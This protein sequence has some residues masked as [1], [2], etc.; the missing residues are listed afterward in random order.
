VSSTL[1]I[2]LLTEELPPKSLL[3]LSRSFANEIFTALKSEGFL[4]AGSESAAFATPRRLA[5]RITRVEAAQPDRALERKGPQVAA[6]L[7]AS[8]NPTPALLGFASSCGVAVHALTK[9]RSDKGEYFVYRSTKPGEKLDEGLWPIV[10]QAIKRLPV[11]KIMRWGEGEAEFVRPVHGLVMLHGEQVVPGQVLGLASTRVTQGHRFMGEGKLTIPHADHYEQLLR[12]R[13]RVIVDFHERLRLIQAELKQAAGDAELLA[14]P[15]LLEEVTALVEQPVVYSGRFDASFLSVPKECLILSMKQHQKY[16]PLAQPNGTLL[17]RFLIVA[18]IDPDDPQNVIHGN[19]RVLRARLSDAKFFY[20][21]DRKTRLE[22]RLP[23]LAQVVYQNKLGSQLERAERISKLSGFLAKQLNSDA[24]LAERAGLLCKADLVTGMVG[25][26][27][28]LQG[29]MGGYYARHD[30]EP[31]AVALAI[32]A[33]YHPRFA[34]DSLPQEV[35]GQAVALAD[36][37]DALAGLFGIG[38]QPTGDKDPY[39]LRRQALGVIRIIVEGGLPLSLFDLVNAA[40]SVFPAGLVGA[41]HTDLA[42][43]I[44]ERLRGYLRDGG[45]SASQVESVLCMRPVRI[46]LIPRQ[47]AAVRAFID[48][49]EAQSLSAAN[50]RVVNILKQAEA[51]GESFIN[52]EA[53][54]LREPAEHAL[55]DALRKTSEHATSLFK[56]GDFTGYLKTFAVLKSPVDAFFDSVMVMVDDAALRR[57][58]LALLA[59][60]RREMNRVADISKLAA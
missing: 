3:R 34:N 24:A 49:P 15:E 7:N 42:T 38:Q 4:A 33:H 50:K 29:I 43:F 26:F 53:G 13:G 31:E 36:K 17:A 41:A 32:R 57:N 58:R 20:D 8:G 35:I 51:R 45:Y 52:A 10:K 59:D 30:G 1:L 39:A 60:L 27:P 12:E 5:V 54:M 40:F 21:Q 14:N 19:E 56:Q 18:N 16:F 22:A 9:Q 25:E 37:L 47:L 6:G 11:A 2:E 48:L 55:F 46:D 28:E 23:K 44:F